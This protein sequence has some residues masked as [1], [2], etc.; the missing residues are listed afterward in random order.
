MT[1]SGRVT[2]VGAMP[3]GSK[4]AAGVPI[5]GPA[6]FATRRSA[7]GVLNYDTTEAPPGGQLSSSAYSWI[8]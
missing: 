3:Q 6:D 8:L 4:R 1:S 7:A 5:V 2:P